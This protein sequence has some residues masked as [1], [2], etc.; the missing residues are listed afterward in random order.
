MQNSYFHLCR[1]KCSTGRVTCCLRKLNSYLP[2]YG[3]ETYTSG[4]PLTLELPENFI[5][6]FTTCTENY[7]YEV[8]NNLKKASKL[9]ASIPIKCLP[10]DL[11]LFKTLFFDSMKQLSL[12]F[13]LTLSGPLSIFSLFNYCLLKFCLLA[14]LSPAPYYSFNYYIG[15][16]WWLSGKESA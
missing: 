14:S 12:D 15:L 8:T 11:P 3:N 7:F 1:N 10:N 2:L 13:P 9:I 16:H 4:K 6:L 5:L